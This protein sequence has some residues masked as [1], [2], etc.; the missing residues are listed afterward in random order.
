MKLVKVLC[1]LLLVVSLVAC[2]NTDVKKSNTF[3]NT[4][5]VAL[6]NEYGANG[7][8]VAYN[9]FLQDGNPDWLYSDLS[10]IDGVY[11]DGIKAAVEGLTFTE[12]GTCGNAI[13]RVVLQNGAN[14]V[15][16]YVYDNATA[17]IRTDNGEE[18][19]TVS[20]DAINT[21]VGAIKEAFGAYE[22]FRT[23]K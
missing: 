13:A 3:D 12:G 11:F 19:Y 5:Y 23:G 8:K 16:L 2:S 14:I 17:S 21:L 4:A 6:M 18:V 20:Q 22:A 10:K 1:S 9:T 7:V 15:Y